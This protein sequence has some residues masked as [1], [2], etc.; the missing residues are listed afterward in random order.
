MTRFLS[1]SEAARLVPH[2]YEC[3]RLMCVVCD[4]LVKG[5]KFERGHWMIPDDAPLFQAA[6]DPDAQ[7][8]KSTPQ[9]RVARLERIMGNPEKFNR[10]IRRMA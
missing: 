5:T 6:P 9:E 1:I 3:I 2:K 8:V 4:P 10:L 7:P